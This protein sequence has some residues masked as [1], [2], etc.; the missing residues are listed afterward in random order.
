MIRRLLAVLA[1]AAVAVV[2][3]AS[4]AHAHVDLDP[5]EAVAGSTTTL[6]FSFHH[7][8]DGTATTKLEV[9]LPEGASVVDLPAVEGWTSELDAATGTVTWSGGPV[10]DGTEAAFPVEVQLP[11]TPG[12]TLFKTIQTTEAGELAWIEEEES[13]AEGAYPAPRLMLTADPNA[14]TT[15]TTATPATTTTAAE[16]GT[17]T[18]ERLAGTTLEAAQRDDG[19]NSAAPWLVGSGIAALVVVGAGGLLL[20]RRAG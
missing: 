1:L 8:K 10:P 11:S 12:E 7:G 14:S 3:F 4:V 19:S 9:L 20:K 16:T 17:E 2:V 5:G 6:T 15:T 18:T 13:E